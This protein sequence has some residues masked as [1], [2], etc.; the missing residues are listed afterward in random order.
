MAK[1]ATLDDLRRVDGKAELVGGEIVRMTPAGDRH[2]RASLRI[3][4]CLL[5]FEEHTGRGRAYGDNVGFRVSLPN[6]QSFSPDAAYYY[7]PHAGDDFLEGPPAFAVEIRSPEDYGPRAEQRL[8]AK[9]ADYFAAG[10]LVV[11]DVDLDRARVCVYRSASQ[12]SPTVLMR[13]DIV[14]A[15]PAIP[16][17]SMAVDELLT[18]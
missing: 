10:T 18:D 9:R 1:G 4:R 17:W 15:E 8:A 12:D 16:D 7:G 11:W 6:R 2:A 14:D 3:A 13:G 5:A